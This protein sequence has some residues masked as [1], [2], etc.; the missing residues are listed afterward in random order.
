MHLNVHGFLIIILILNVK[1]GND[2]GRQCYYILLMT[3]F[4]YTVNDSRQCYLHTVNDS[5]QCYYILLMTVDSV[6]IYC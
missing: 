6:T 4:L 1:F 5:R 3:V 2:Q